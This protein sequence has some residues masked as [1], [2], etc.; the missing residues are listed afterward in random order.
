MYSAPP[1]DGSFWEFSAELRGDAFF[2]T[3]AIGLF[4]SPRKYTP[5][6]YKAKALPLSSSESRVFQKPILL[7][8]K[9]QVS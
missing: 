4:K 7:K 3:Q 8:D 2:V 1:A 6:K 5:R 9:L